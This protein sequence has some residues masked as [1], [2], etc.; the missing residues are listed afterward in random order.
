M[1]DKETKSKVAQLQ[2]LHQNLQ[3]LLVQK[4]HFQLQL[5]ET[6][7]ALKEVKDSQQ[8]YKII[9]NIMVLSSA[10][11][12]DTDLKEKRETFEL[13]LKNIETQEERLR[14]KSEELQKQLMA[15]LK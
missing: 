5:N 1:A 4:Q 2:M 8:A 15:E 12:I 9:G 14:K 7:S 10:A 11:A 3:T 13:R 6:E